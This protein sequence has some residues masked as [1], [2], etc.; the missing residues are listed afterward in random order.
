MQPFPS[1]TDR[2]TIGV[3]V[4]SFSSRHVRHRLVIQEAV[5]EML[6][7]AAEAA[8]LDRDLWERQPGGDGEVAVL[9]VGID[10][11][12]VVLTFVRTLDQLLT[13]HNGDH[14]EELQVRLRVAMHIGTITAGA[15]GSGGDALVDLS[16]LLDSEP[17]R[18]AL[19]AHRE[20][21]L[22]LIVS[23]EV[24]RKVVVTELGGLRPRQFTEVRVDI[25]AKG[26]SRTAYVHVPGV[27]T[28]K[29]VPEPGAS[30]PPPEPAGGG[31]QKA[32]YNIFSEPLNMN[33][34]VFGFNEND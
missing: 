3:D 9:P 10:L 28:I 13:D 16:R 8:G 23:D 19:V 7:S 34:P 29:E 26:F 20:A 32:V 12:A 14:S 6:S 33:N 4:K 22:A 5:D 25:P 31:A 27:E 1:L 18:A 17:V 2:F 15:L 11:L 24:Y 21:N 30:G